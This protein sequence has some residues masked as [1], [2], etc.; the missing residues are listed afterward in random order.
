MRKTVRR[1]LSTTISRLDPDTVPEDNGGDLDDVVAQLERAAAEAGRR[2]D[3]MES[4]SR[5]VTAALGE[6]A[7]GVV[8][9]DQ[10]GTVVY[11]NA[12]AA[13]FVGA[14]HGEALAER[15]LSEL[16]GA[17]VAGEA[18]EETIELFS[19]PRRTLTIRRHASGRRRRGDRRRGHHRR[20]LGE[21]PARSRAPGFRRQHQPRAEDPGRARSA[22][23]PRPS[24]ART[25]RR[26]WPACPIACAPKPSGSAASSRISSTCPE[27]RRKS[28]RSG[29]RC[30][31]SMVLAEAIERLRPVAD[32]G[33]IRL[34]ASEPPYALAIVGDRRQ[35]VSAV[36]NLVD[37]A[38]K[39]SERGSAVRV[40]VS[41]PRWRHRD[42]RGRRR[43]R[44]PVPRPRADLRTVLPGGPGPLARHRWHRSRP[45]HRP[46]RGQ[47]SRR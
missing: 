39:Y 28:C 3:D 40:V 26:W 25:I 6:V 13:V 30:R 19:P 21:A 31:S 9:C 7:Q 44:H 46:P 11:R 32:H 38:I 10:S 20:R 24:K 1:R 41:R 14:R 37:N 2:L 45:G 16:L 35:L 5:R 36:H 42:R 15:S 34:E 17:A 18:R 23:W 33:G 27:S 22:W 4:T 12:Q 43:H 29:S 47:Q 8:V